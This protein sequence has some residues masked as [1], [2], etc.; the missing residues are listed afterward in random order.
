MSVHSVEIICWPPHSSYG[1][2]KVLAETLIHS[3]P[4]LSDLRQND[5]GQQSEDNIKYAEITGM[6]IASAMREI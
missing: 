1:R 5:L 4:H 6:D 2:E 3:Q